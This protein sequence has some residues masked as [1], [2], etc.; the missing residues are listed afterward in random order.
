MSIYNGLFEA[1]KALKAGFGNLKEQK[2]TVRQLAFAAKESE[3]V[4]SAGPALGKVAKYAAYPAGVGAG[5]GLGAAAAGVGTG[6]GAEAAGKG[7][8]AGWAPENL[9]GAGK[10]AFGVGLL[11]VFVVAAVFLYRAVK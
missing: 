3:T 7:I 9:A 10:M 11:I 6:A 1:S 5:V 8:M 2:A 4:K